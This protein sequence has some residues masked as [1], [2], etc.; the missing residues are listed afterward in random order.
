MTIGSFVIGK[1]LI[2]NHNQILEVGYCCFL[3][4]RFK[5]FSATKYVMNQQSFMFQMFSN[6]RN[7]VLLN[8]LLKHTSGNNLSLGEHT[9]FLTN[10]TILDNTDIIPST[11]WMINGDVL[12]LQSKYI[13]DMEET[14]PKLLLSDNKLTIKPVTFSRNCSKTWSNGVLQIEDKDTLVRVQI[15]GQQE[16]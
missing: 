8:T 15:Q 4:F 12:K 1:N 16:V 3:I 13:H 10:V 6:V 9:V 11:P 5:C 14:N 2:V 7:Y